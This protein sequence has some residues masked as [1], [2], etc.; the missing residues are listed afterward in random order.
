MDDKLSS[1]HDW[2]SESHM[3]DYS[4]RPNSR[5][6]LSVVEV[7]SDC[8][9]HHPGY[10][11]WFVAQGWNFSSTADAKDGKKTRKTKKKSPLVV[12]YVSCDRVQ[13]S[14]RE[15]CKTSFGNTAS[16]RR[17]AVMSILIHSL[18]S[19]QNRK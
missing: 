6:F 16:H 11:L 1:G 12:I 7:F 4:S 17:D 3:A 10:P 18:K 19:S 13:S 9:L 15:M 2:S 8:L 14:E 5:Y